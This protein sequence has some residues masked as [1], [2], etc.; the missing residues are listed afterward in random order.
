MPA[1]FP[2]VRFFFADY[3]TFKSEA[4]FHYDHDRAL[5]LLG[6]P[7]IDLYFLPKMLGIV[8]AYVLLVLAYINSPAAF[9]ISVVT[10]FS[11]LRPNLAVNRT[12]AGVADHCGRSVGAGYLIR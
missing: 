10:Q 12:P 4:G 11:L 2:I 1:L 9:Y 8:A 3:E 7:R 5:W 6:L